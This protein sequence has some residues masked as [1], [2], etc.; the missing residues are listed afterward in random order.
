MHVNN[1]QWYKVGYTDN[2]SLN[3]KEGGVEEEKN[4]R[5][6]LATTKPIATQCCGQII[7]LELQT[8]SSLWLFQLDDSQSLHGKWLFHQTSI[9]NWLFRVPGYIYI[10]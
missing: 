1:P 6:K 9:T 5:L 7:F 8:T 10:S 4:K 2:I 3:K